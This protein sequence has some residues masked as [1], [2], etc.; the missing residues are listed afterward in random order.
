[1]SDPAR[2][3][4]GED[5]EFAKALEKRHEHLMEGRK[6]YP[7]SCKSEASD[8]ENDRLISAV[9]VLELLA[10]FKTSPTDEA[11]IG[12]RRSHVT[13]E[14]SALIDAENGNTSLEA[15]IPDPHRLGRFEI[16]NQLGRGGY[17]IVI[18]AFD[19]DLNRVVAIKIP[20]LEAA[21]SSDARSRFQREA[22]AAA[23]L[24]HPGVVAIYETGSDQGVDYIVSEYVEGENLAEF[25]AQHDKLSP[26]QTA[27]L[28]ADLACAVAHAHQRGVLHRDL[29]PSN[30][31][32]RS[33][34]PSIEPAISDFGLASFVDQQDI[35]QSGA[36]V[37]TPAYMSPE[38]AT[39]CL[40]MSGPATDVYGL[41]TILYQLLT[42]K[43]PFDGLSIL[44]TIRAIS[45]TDPSPPRSFDSAVPRDLEAICLKCLEK[46][47]AKRYESA[48]ALRTDL[49]HF[50]ESR[51][52]NARPVT[53]WNRLQRWAKRNPALA[54]ATTAFFL[55]LTIGLVIALALWRTSENHRLVAETNKDKYQRRSEEL[56]ALVDRMFERV[57]QMPEI[58]VHGMEPVREQMLD[59]VNHYY[60]ILL[61]ET[62]SNPTLKLKQ[63]ETALR[64]AG[65]KATLSDHQGA[66]DAARQIL[67]SIPEDTE[68]ARHQQRIDAL[69]IMSQ[70][71]WSMGD[72][73]KYQEYLDK[74]I[75]WSR[76]VYTS[77]SAPTIAD[78]ME[79]A[80][81]LSDA[82]RLTSDMG[83]R[84]TSQKLVDESIQVWE[85]IDPTTIGNKSMIAMIDS[86]RI[87]SS[88]YLQSEDRES[89]LRY[90]RKTIELIERRLN[91]TY[92][93]TPEVQYLL[94]KTY[95]NLGAANRARINK[96]LPLFE[97]SL[98]IA[99]ALAAAHPLVPRYRRQIA[100]INY[101]RGLEHY[102][103][104]AYNRNDPGA[105]KH[106]QSALDVFN[107]GIPF[108]NDLRVRFPND[109]QRF[110]PI[111]TDYMTMV[112]LV[113]EEQK[114]YESELAM[115]KQALKL[116]EAIDREIQTQRSRL[117]VLGIQ[118]NIGK[119]YLNL[120]RYRESLPV[121]SAA[122]KGYSEI[123][124]RDPA[125]GTAARFLSTTAE[126][127]AKSYNAL[128]RHGDALAA[129]RQSTG[130][131]RDGP[132]ETMM[133][134]EVA[135]MVLAGEIET[136]AKKF[137]KF[138]DFQNSLLRKG[139]VWHKDQPPQPNQLARALPKLISQASRVI[140]AVNSSSHATEP[141]YSLLKVQTTN[142]AIEALSKLDRDPN[143]PKEFLSNVLK[144][145]E[146]EAL[147]QTEA[148]QSW[149]KSREQ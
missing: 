97:Q 75:S 43:A 31:L 54:I 132:A 82:A 79:Y 57:Q 9:R 48:F 137:T 90:G 63:A 76:N 140:D 133:G 61:S 111:L 138:A 44:E 81:S 122:I 134:G 55:S 1:M 117:R 114:N 112:G 23:A 107:K 22:R 34:D 65:L 39:G 118:G 26:R 87:A 146:L 32:L 49:Q 124:E 94:S 144:S 25:L 24:N 68:K 74:A 36:V 41:G 129:Y 92:R 143:L 64:L 18:K 42:G 35:T 70:A 105:E 28:V 139:A 59:D 128:G 20:R 53:Q 120:K 56:E 5:A 123:L 29:K 14:S 127:C 104:G 80:K 47:P 147:R 13:V 8:L 73:E 10:E 99:T 115:L 38:Q 27:E 93:N 113:F 126:M 95:F 121:F 84:T 50:L 149:Q 33:T 85:D 45:E 77:V 30:V 119:S 16:S 98:E 3:S 109:R 62:P 40:R 135:Y 89:G 145:S 69:L 91:E 106:L 67:D 131:Y 7:S 110:E 6:D 51:P 136:A 11:G 102:I 96:S 19:P 130:A 78:R 46:D 12:T 141:A 72:R 83:D 101:Q 142:A 66:V 108:L 52:V 103:A 58:S 37:G 60:K 86:Y 71:Y 17:G 21:L 100:L 4:L 88:T 148:F 2:P 125:N 15:L 116:A